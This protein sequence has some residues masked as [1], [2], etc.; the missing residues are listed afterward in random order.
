MPAHAR[1]SRGL[2]VY[3]D[4]SPEPARAGRFG[5]LFPQTQ[6][7]LD[8]E[9]LEAL[10]R[11]MSGEGAEEDTSLLDDDEDENRERVNDELRL[12]SGYT[13]FGQFIDHDLTLDPVS[14][15]ERE[16][17]AGARID[18]R[19]PRFDLDSVYGSGPDDQPYMYDASEEK[20]LE[21]VEGDVLRLGA[22]AVLG[23]ARNDEN[24]LVVQ[25]HRA[26]VRL[27]NRVVDFLRRDSGQ[28]A[29]FG[30]AQVLVR[31]TYQWLI[32]NDFA[33]RILDAATW[34]ILRERCKPENDYPFPAPMLNLYEESFMP[35]EFSGA[36]YRF[37]HSMV[38]P[39]YHLNDRI[40]RLMDRG[41]QQ[42]GKNRIPV[43]ANE[44]PSLNGFAPLHSLGVASPAT[45]EWKYFF[46]FEDQQGVPLQVR[47]QDGT[48]RE[49]VQPAYRIDTT[50]VGPL[51]D[52]TG[53]RVVKT[54]APSLAVRNLQR[55]RRLR[56]PTGQEVAKVLGHE[57]LDAGR[58]LLAPPSNGS[59]TESAAE[60][61]RE[62]CELLGKDSA[63][64]LARTTPL[65]YYL[66]AEAQTQAGGAHLGR[67]G[68]TLVGGVLLRLL[69][70]D[71]ESY[72]RKD[73]EFSPSRVFGVR[74]ESL[75][76]L[77][78]WVEPEHVGSKRPLQL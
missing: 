48:E 8:D 21:G 2:S 54:G 39:S 77:L 44:P 67:L 10:G 5:R 75:A 7:E 47:G 70:N 11:S 49:I 23:D 74:L 15:F 34:R 71:A 45:L 52:L 46:P 57:I 53:P 41:T 1:P 3:Q 36:A 65:W 43:F 56:I 20:L 38:R 62:R 50:L 32:V 37:G 25:L 63:A 30:P 40:T 13:Y 69:L 17:D 58:L 14:S 12:S 33:P 9:L 18:F 24:K 29:A 31:K 64:V 68:S 16:F 19:T 28:R 60:V 59:A 6:F 42:R 76:D 35:V 72:L 73:P 4:D 78:A 26:F 22:R 61:A 51:A 55:G 27:H 66:L